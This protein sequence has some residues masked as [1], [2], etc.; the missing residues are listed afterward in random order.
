MIARN[1]SEADLLQALELINKEYDNNIKFKRLENRNT[2]K[3]K[4]FIFTLTVKNSHNA[5]GRISY[6][7]GGK[8]RRVK[9]AC[10]HV[11]GRFFDILL[12]F[13]PNCTI[14]TTT[15]KGLLKIYRAGDESVNN[16]QDWNIGSSIQPYYYSQACN[17][18]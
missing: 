13:N 9:A 3:Q 14:I 6:N 10:W 1:C 4:S 17:C 18:N 7:F 15:N 8:S 12:S 16:W 11:H 5:G 2:K